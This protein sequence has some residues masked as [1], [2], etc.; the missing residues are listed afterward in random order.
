MDFIGRVTELEKL[1]SEYTR[2]SASLILLHGRPK[3]GKTSLIRK[4][5]ENKQYFYFLA[6][7]ESE[8]MN[9]DAFKRLVA[10]YL[11]DDLLRESVVESWEIIFKE[12]L[13]NIGTQRLLIVIDDFQNLLYNNVSF[14]SLFQ[15]IWDNLLSKANVMVILSSSLVSSISSQLLS[16]SSLLYGRFTSQIRLLP[17]SFSQYQ[18]YMKK[19]I[20]E[21]ELVKRYSVTGGFPKYIEAL[22]NTDSLKKAIQLNLLNPSSLIYEEPL[23]LIQKELREA[24]VYISI[25]R[26]IAACNNNLT[27]IAALTQQKITNLPRYLKVLMDLDIIERD[28]S[29]TEKNPEKSR[30]GRYRIKDNFQSFWFKYIYPNRSYIEIGKGDSVIESLFKS[31]VESHVSEV[32]K[33]ICQEKLW[34]LSAKGLLPG[35]LE[36]VGHWWDNSHEIDVV[37]LSEKDDLLVVGECKFWKGPVGSNILYQLEQK[38]AFIDWHK[39]SRKTIYVIFSING[40]NE[41]LKSVADSRDDVLLTK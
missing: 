37:G 24:G 32:Y 41:E 33:Q 8:A 1:D 17:L 7:E 36:R 6:S 9:R 14:L 38:T 21:M 2:D 26:S 34:T 12:L 35:L 27:K 4:F 15:S 28:V 5:V 31:F 30:R 3:V 11:N 19:D 13:S 22:N 39:V 10:D 18:E 23:N 29:V 20:S 40:F 25:L 16:Y